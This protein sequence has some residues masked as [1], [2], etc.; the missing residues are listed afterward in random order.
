MWPQRDA[1]EKKE[2]KN[3]KKALQWSLLSFDFKRDP[4]REEEKQ[5]TRRFPHTVNEVRQ[6][7]NTKDTHSVLLFSQTE[8]ERER[9]RRRRRDKT[10]AIIISM[11]RRRE[12]KK[13]IL[14]SSRA[15]SF[16]RLKVKSTTETTNEF[17]LFKSR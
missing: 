8:R 3:E 10:A 6:Q 5:K 4:K 17:F 1:E 9:R 7:Q 16:L 11:R 13:K 12:K 14:I 15:L 2:K